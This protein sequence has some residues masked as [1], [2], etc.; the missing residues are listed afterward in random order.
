MRLPES[1]SSADLEERP[2]GEAGE[3]RG[4]GRDQPI[5]RLTAQFIKPKKCI[6]ELFCLGRAN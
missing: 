5:A 6:S 4:F 3:A 1:L 2:Y